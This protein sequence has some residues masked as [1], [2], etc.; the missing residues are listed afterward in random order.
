MS[1][2]A[3]N[4]E[5]QQSP[6]DSER[7]ARPPQAQQEQS[8]PEAPAEDKHVT[9]G[10]AEFEEL[11]TL[12]AERDEYLKR[13]QRAVADYLNLQKRIER[14][15][16]AAEKEALRKVARQVVPLADSLARALEAAEAT[17]GAE[18]IV[19]GLR[20]MEKEFYAMLR[21]LNIQP[22]QA[23]GE[24]FNPDYHEAVLRQPTDE[25][26]PNT[27]VKELKKGFL[28]GDEL[29]RPTQVIVA[30]RPEGEAEQ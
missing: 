1:S 30:A 18:T 25:V 10:R 6:G 19:E 4:D 15:R 28:L 7:E 12:A 21:A 16:E 23:E 11:R 17:R 9:I 3:Q 5:K 29:L 26:A 2:M 24:A 27:V 22:I 20:V 14:M 13:L 8:Q